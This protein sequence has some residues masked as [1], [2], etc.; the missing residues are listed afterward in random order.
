MAER[1]SP[2]FAWL[3]QAEHDSRGNLINTLLRDMETGDVLRANLF[4]GEHEGFPAKLLRGEIIR[5]YN[6]TSYKL[7]GELRKGKLEV[8]KRIKWS[9]I[10]F[11]AIHD[12]WWRGEIHARILSQVRLERR[13]VSP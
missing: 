2:I 9:H 10:M 1:N 8:V 11:P 3:S 13:A 6:H 7:V 4:G 12:P 5:P